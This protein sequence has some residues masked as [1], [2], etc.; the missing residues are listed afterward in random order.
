M[1]VS[2]QTRQEEQDTSSNEYNTKA[3]RSPHASKYLKALTV[4]TLFLIT[5]GLKY[6]LRCFVLFCFKELSEL[7]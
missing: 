2:F 4:T 5:T 3:A 1:I 7:K 6:N